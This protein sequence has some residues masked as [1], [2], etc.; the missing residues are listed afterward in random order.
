MGASESSQH[1]QANSQPSNEKPSTLTSQNSEEDHTMPT[2]KAVSRKTSDLRSE[3]KP[4]PHNYEAIVKDAAIDKSSTEKLF[5]QLYTGLLLKQKK[6]KYWVDKKS[7]ANFFMLYARSFTITWSEDKRF[8]HWP[9]LSE[10]DGVF[11][12]VAEM[13]NVCWLEVHGKLEASML[14]PGVLYEFVF[15]VML[16][17]PAYGWEVPVNLRLTRPDGSKQ[18]HK[19]NL[20]EKPRGRWIEIVIGEF[21]ASQEKSGEIECSLYEYQGGKWKKGLLVKGVAVRPK[22]SIKV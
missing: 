17:D 16:R 9:Y 13:L 3:V 8:W 4:P 12:D 21:M 15:E 22:T 20:M 18:E 10:S 11:I 2:Q 14:S 1:D 6:Q 5:E 19:E 7:H